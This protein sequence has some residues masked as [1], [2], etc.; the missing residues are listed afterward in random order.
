[1]L[2]HQ[3]VGRQKGWALEGYETSITAK[4]Q[5]NALIQVLE[6]QVFVGVVR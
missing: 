6:I 3:N 2:T 5:V 1:M 4:G